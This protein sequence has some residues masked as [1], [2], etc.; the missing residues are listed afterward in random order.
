M[1]LYL[2]IGVIALFPYNHAAAEKGNAYIVGV[3]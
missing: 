2:M 3:P 1:N